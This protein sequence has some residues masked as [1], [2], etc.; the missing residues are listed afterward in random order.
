LEQNHHKSINSLRLHIIRLFRLLVVLLFG[1]PVVDVE[2]GE[3]VQDADDGQLHPDDP[4]E[5]FELNWSFD[6]PVFCLFLSDLLK[7]S[8]EIVKK[9]DTVLF[10]FGLMLVYLVI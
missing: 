10:L 7:L 4:E 5:K 6:I 3:P 2:R 1:R 9:K 8:S